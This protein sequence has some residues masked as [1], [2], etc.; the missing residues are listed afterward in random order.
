V[1]SLTDP[2]GRNL[3]FLGRSR[4]FFFQISPQLYYKAEWTPFQTHCFSENLIA[5]GI[6]PG[7]LNLLSGILTTRPQ[8]RSNNKIIFGSVVLYM[9]RVVS[10]ENRR[11]V[12]SRNSIFTIVLQKHR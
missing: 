8:R 2:Y 5:P 9:V 1:V 12:L 3:G 4:Y 10:K 11:L 7:P 6:E